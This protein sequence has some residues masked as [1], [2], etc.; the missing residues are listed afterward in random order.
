[1]SATTYNH[2]VVSVNGGA[3]LAVDGR[4]PLTRQN[5]MCEE[6][7][8]RFVSDPMNDDSHVCKWCIEEE[9]EEEEVEEEVMSAG[10]DEED[11]ENEVNLD[12][13]VCMRCKYE[14]LCGPADVEE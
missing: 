9:E 4:P 10:E 3:T 7:R 6:C 5:A 1:M 13:C 12:G 11:A 2:V 8:M 14:V